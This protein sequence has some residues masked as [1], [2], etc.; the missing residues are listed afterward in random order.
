MRNVAVPVRNVIRGVSAPLH[1]AIYRLI[2]GKE[3]AWAP[4]EER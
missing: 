4:G 3:A 1:T 2:K